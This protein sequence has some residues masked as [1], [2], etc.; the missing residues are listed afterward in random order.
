MPQR[1]AYDD[2][3]GL[4]RVEEGIHGVGV[5]LD[6]AHHLLWFYLRVDLGVLD[7][8]GGA[9]DLAVAEEGVDVPHVVGVPEDAP[10][11]GAGDTL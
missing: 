11:S 3:P 8:G 2:V 5:P 6:L 1:R 10:E 9:D 4:Q 7:G